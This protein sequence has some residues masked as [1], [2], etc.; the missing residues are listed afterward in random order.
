MEIPKQNSF[1][2]LS[3]TSKLFIILS[4]ILIAVI[5]FI[6]NDFRLRERSFLVLT[7]IFLLLS[8]LFGVFTQMTIANTLNKISKEL[9]SKKN[10]IKRLAIQL[11]FLLS[12]LCFITGVVF[13]ILFVAKIHYSGRP[14]ML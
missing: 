7:Q 10:T 2:T 11:P 6:A 12:F 1:R 14:I 4:I 13:I 3:E 8:F 5:L 9:D